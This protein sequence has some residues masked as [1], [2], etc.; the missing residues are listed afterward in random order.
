MKLHTDL[1]VQRLVSRPVEIFFGDL[2][3][4]IPKSAIVCDACNQQ[5][6]VTEQDLKNLAMGYAVVDGEFI[7]EV[8]CE[9]CR[10][11]YFDDI[12]VFDTLEDAEEVYEKKVR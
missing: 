10:Q 3:T 9:E 11:R 5:V 1:R 7:L 12:P 4:T 8:V 6:A 2:V